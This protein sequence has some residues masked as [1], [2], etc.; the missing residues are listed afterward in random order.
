MTVG[1]RDTFLGRDFGSGPVGDARTM[2]VDT[3]WAG[4]RA[5]NSYDPSLS[6][7]VAGRNRSYDSYDLGG[8]VDVLDGTRGN[9]ALFFTTSGSARLDAAGNPVATAEHFVSVERFVLDMGDDVLDLTAGPGGAG[10]YATRVEAYGD[11]DYGQSSAAYGDDVLWGGRA[12]ADIL[13][14]DTFQL[15]GTSVGGDDLLHAGVSG[16][17]S[18]APPISPATPASPP[19]TATRPGRPAR[20]CAATTCWSAG[21]AATSSTPTPGP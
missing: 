10:S 11:T 14:G 9:D 18:A 1:L 17:D 19:S 8:G 21:T 16:N 4:T 13:A 3:T 6:V 5:R 20:A 2:E 12:P 7:S 15:G